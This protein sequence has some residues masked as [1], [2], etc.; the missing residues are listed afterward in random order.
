MNAFTGSRF[1][2]CL[3]SI[4]AFPSWTYGQTTANAT[5][6]QALQQQV[7][8]LK[9]QIADLEDKIKNLTSTPPATSDSSG[10][11]QAKGSDAQQGSKTSEAA[12]ELKTEQTESKATAELRW[13][14]LY[15]KR[16][17]SRT[18]ATSAAAL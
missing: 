2:L 10:A 8:S 3:L 4:A 17:H 15:G 5:D 6:A 16:R 12:K 1:F 7:D 11:P 9:T 18:G 13:P 14:G